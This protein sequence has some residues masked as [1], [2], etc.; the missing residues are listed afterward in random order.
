MKRIS[1]RPV[2]LKKFNKEKQI[3]KILEELDEFLEVSDSQDKCRESEEICD[4]IQALIT[5]HHYKIG[6]FKEWWNE[7]HLPKMEKREWKPREK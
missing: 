2:I 1:F 3:N 5:Y 6:D 4:A 7:Y